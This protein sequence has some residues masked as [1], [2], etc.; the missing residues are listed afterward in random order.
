MKIFD[1]RTHNLLEND[2]TRSRQLRTH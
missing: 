2:Q 1:S